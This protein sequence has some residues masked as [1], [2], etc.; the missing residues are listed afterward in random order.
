MR[1]SISKFKA[2]G[3]LLDFRAKGLPINSNSKFSLKR[4]REL[5]I[6][7]G[8]G[9]KSLTPSLGINLEL[10]WKLELIMRRPP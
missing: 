4:E 1:R 8:I 10:T 9:E 6:G 2:R 7:N 5:G 3:R